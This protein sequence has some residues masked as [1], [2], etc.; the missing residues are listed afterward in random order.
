VSVGLDYGLWCHRQ[1][2]GERELDSVSARAR[3]LPDAPLLSVLLVA[4]EL[5]EL[6]IGAGVTSLARQAYSRWEL[7]PVQF[8]T[9][10]AIDDVLAARMPDETRIR[11]AWAPV[12]PESPQAALARALS[13]ATGD[14]VLVLDEGDELSIDAL[15]RVVDAIHATDADLVYSNEDRIDAT[16]ARSGPVFKPGFSPDRLLS[17]PDLGRMCAIR[18]NLVE[19][20]GGLQPELG[21]VAEH[22]LLLR[23]TERARRVVHLPQVLYHRRVLSDAERRIVWGAADPPPVDAAAAVVE[24]ALERR[25]EQATVRTDRDSGM[26]RVIRRPPAEARATLI[27]RSDRVA[28]AMPL[29]HQLERRS[30]VGIDDVIVAGERPGRNCPWPVVEDASQARAANR[31]AALATGDVLIFCAHTGALPPSAGPRWVSELV[32]QATRAEIGAVSGTVVDAEGLRHGGRR[33]DLEGLAGPASREHDLEGLSAGRPIN[34]GGASGDLLAIERSKFEAVE[35]FD[36]EHLPGAL[37]ALDLAFRLEEEGWLSVYTPVAQIVC[38][39]SRAF[40]SADEAEYMWWRWSSRLNRLL[41]YEWAP[42]D[43]R[44]SPL[45]PQHPGHATFAGGRTRMAAA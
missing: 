45:A 40:P 36:A 23:V 26:V 16:G 28:A 19:A 20:A 4:G 6:W 41:D 37:F 13:L 44:R 2:A 29:P 25:R 30:T 35:G 1:E 34:A 14:Y 17:A 11:A 24:A 27:L 31:A 5:D 12:E 9:R 8:G 32:A 18:R 33:V 43:P 21:P 7:C 22:D 38:R 42:L 10:T 3:S 15:L 39:D